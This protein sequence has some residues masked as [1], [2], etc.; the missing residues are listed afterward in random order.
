MQALFLI[1]CANP[2]KVI[3]TLF[4]FSGCLINELSSQSLPKRAVIFPLKIVHQPFIG[5]SWTLMCHYSCVTGMQCETCSRKT[6][7][8]SHRGLTNSSAS[9]W[10][11]KLLFFSAC[12]KK[13]KRLFLMGW[14]CQMLYTHFHAWC[15]S[16]DINMKLIL[17]RTLVCW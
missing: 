1:L 13:K 17:M 14:S 5:S 9:I 15:T 10:E 2:L 8:H 12:R 7:Q 3:R 16:T 4:C 6:G 11:N